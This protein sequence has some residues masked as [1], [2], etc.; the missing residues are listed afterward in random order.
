MPPMMRK[1]RKTLKRTTTTKI[2][3]LFFA[4]MDGSLE[5]AD[6]SLPTFE[7]KRY[8]ADVFLSASKPF[9][10]AG[11]KKKKKK[12]VTSTSIEAPSDSLELD[13]FAFEGK[14]K[15]KKP[16]APIPAVNEDDEKDYDYFDLLSSF[17]RERSNA[18]IKGADL[19]LPTLSTK[20]HR[21]LLHLLPY[22]T[23][24]QKS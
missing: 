15:K 18:K 12:P 2:K 14:K 3:E 7:R 13:G 16:V 1:K 19:S 4:H 20:S 22:L 9:R 6:S 10:T 23:R 21:F 11:M 8:F 5:G 17:Y 24:T